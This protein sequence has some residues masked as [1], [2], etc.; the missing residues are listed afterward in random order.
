MKVPAKAESVAKTTPTPWRIFLTLARIVSLTLGGGYAIVPAIGN[1]F[2]KQGWIKEEEFYRVFSR[3]QVFPGPIALTTSFLCAYR[4][5]GVPG[6]VAAVFGVVLPPFFALILVGGFISLYGNTELFKRFLHGAG[7]V[8]PGL[9][10]SMLWRTARNRKWSVRT[11]L[12]VITLAILLA[13][14]PSAAFFILIGGIIV[15]YLGRLI[16]KS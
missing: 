10:G 4:I 9:V 6:A 5:A 16:W 3:A 12:E 2:E 15:L 1:A 11:V 13:L 14:F 7:A 8:V